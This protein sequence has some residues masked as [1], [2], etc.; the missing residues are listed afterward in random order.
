MTFLA[1]FVNEIQRCQSPLI[2]S[3]ASRSQKLRALKLHRGRDKCIYGI[4]QTLPRRDRATRQK[5]MPWI[6]QLFYMRVYSACHECI[7]KVLVIIDKRFTIPYSADYVHYAG[8][9]LRYTRVLFSWKLYVYMCNPEYI[10]N[11][12]KWDTSLS[13]LSLLRY[14]R[15]YKVREENS[16][17]I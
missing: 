8:S 15:A 11:A 4:Y 16:K 9:S 14:F 5:G 17:S 3:F 10:I 12:N 2:I 13:N 7:Q 1:S 6:N